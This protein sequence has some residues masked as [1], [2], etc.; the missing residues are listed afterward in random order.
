MKYCG[1]SQKEQ[2]FALGNLSKLDFDHFCHSKVQ[3]AV[4]VLKIAQALG[5]ADTILKQNSQSED[6][7]ADK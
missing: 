5:K 6:L 1:Y 3:F 2:F 4:Q 7:R